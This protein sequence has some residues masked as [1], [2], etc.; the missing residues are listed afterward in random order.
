[1]ADLPPVFTI[2][3]STRSIEEFVE[4]LRQAQV[5]LVIDIRS[6]PRSWT[7]PHY[8]LDILPEALAVWQIGHEQIIELGGRRN[9]SKSVAPETNNFWTNQSFHNY[10]DY[11][12]SAEFRYG[13]SQLLEYSATRRCTIMCSEAVWWRCHRRFVADYLLHEGREVFH[14]MGPGRA[15]PAKIHPAARPCGAALTYPA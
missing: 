5:Q 7:N 8:N 6:T 14:L 11:A 15:E 2:G 3:H 13:L 4:I 10:A 1:M 9:K 12:L